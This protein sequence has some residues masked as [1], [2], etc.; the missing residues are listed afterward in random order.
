MAGDTL[1]YATQRAPVPW[2]SFTKTVI[3]AAIL[4]LVRDGALHLD[5][6][7]EGR[8]FSLRHLLQNRAGITDYG[9]LRE[10]H[11]AV[12]A[13]EAPWSVE[14][15]LERA[16]ADMLLF[17]PGSAFSYS[18]IGYLMLRQTLERVCDCPLSDAL[19]KLVLAP[20]DISDVK[21][22]AAPTPMPGLRAGYHPDW[23][24]HGLLAGPL[25]QAALLLQ[26]LMQFDLLPVDLL[27][28]MSQGVTVGDEVPGRP[29]KRPAYGLG[30]MV[31]VIDPPV[32][33][34][35][36]GGPDSTLAVYWS[37]AT[38]RAAAVFAANHATGAVETRALILIGDEETA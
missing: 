20:L 9:G 3:A 27:A 30:T 17:P 34:H 32:I 37:P 11:A 33:G 12:E 15:V 24:Y 18:N 13:G 2:W 25:D 7:H 28:Q 10:Y 1:A 26:R 4:A 19:A 16:Q 35:S 8:G 14:D 23:V 22:L 36:G 38:Q 5:E 31:D 29:F 21:L 6:P